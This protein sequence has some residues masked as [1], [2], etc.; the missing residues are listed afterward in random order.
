MKNKAANVVM[1]IVIVILSI[2]LFLSFCLMIDSFNY[3][4]EQREKKASEDYTSVME[5][6]LEH[7]AYDRVLGS[8]YSERLDN[9]EPAEG[10]EDLYN[11]SEYCHLA[12]MSRVYEEEGNGDRTRRCQEKAETV[13]GRLGSYA[14][15]SGEVDA[16]LS[17][18]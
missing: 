10:Y 1:I 5:Y 8:Y 11:I 12:F 14:Y 13:K 18:K 15:V 2:V 6:E 17:G 3:A 9:F 7:K 4:K 16:I